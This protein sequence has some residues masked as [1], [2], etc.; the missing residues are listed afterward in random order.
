MPLET[1]IVKPGQRYRSVRTEDGKVLDPPADWS[2]LKPGDAALTRKVKKAGP[3]WTVQEKKG[4]RTFSQ[5]VWAPTA[6]IEKATIELQETRE[7]PTYQK[8]LQN[9][10]QR[11]EKKEE[12]YGEE[13]K[14]AILTFLN[15]HQTYRSLERKIAELVCTHAIPVGSGTVARTKR[16]PIEERASAAVIAWMRHQTSAYDMMVVPRVKGARREVRRKIAETSRNILRSYR[17]GKEIAQD[18]PLFLALEKHKTD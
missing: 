18:C 4:R 12:A 1:R 14:V 2:L 8:K 3:T 16:I 17:Q 5:G 10:R 11:R 7:D 6:N 13:F 9:E 15:F